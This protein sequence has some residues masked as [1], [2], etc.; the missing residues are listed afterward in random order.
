MPEPANWHSKEQMRRWDLMR[1]ALRGCTFLPGSAHKRFA[2]NIQHVPLEDVTEGQRRCVIRLAQR[3]RR[4]MP[5]DLVPSKDA[6][7]ALDAAWK[8]TIEAQRQGIIAQ[9]A[10]RKAAKRLRKL[11]PPLPFDETVE[12]ASHAQ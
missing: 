7:E 8:Q 9:R 6:V 5:T 12:A 2:R 10:E 11:G 1:V 4:Q 3:Y